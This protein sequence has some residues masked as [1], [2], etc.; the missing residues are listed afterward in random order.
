MSR[1]DLRRGVKTDQRMLLHRFEDRTMQVGAMAHRIR[2]PKARAECL[3]H[4]HR[5][6]LAAI[7]GVHHH[8]PVGEDRAFAHCLAHAQRIERREGIGAQLQAGADFADGGALLEQVDGHAQA[9]QR[10]RRGHAADAAA[11]EQHGGGILRGR[12]A[13]RGDSARRTVN[14]SGP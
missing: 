14:R 11:D 12:C 3:A 13:H 6:H 8:Q 9:G 2:V 7:D 1:F 10:Q 4:L 5:S